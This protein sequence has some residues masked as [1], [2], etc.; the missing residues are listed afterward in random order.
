MVVG[1]LRV[2]QG[3][4]LLHALPIVSWVECCTRLLWQRSGP[5]LA[6][7]E[8]ALR[9]QGGRTDILW[10]VLLQHPEHDLLYL[11]D[12]FCSHHISHDTLHALIDVCLQDL[13]SGAPARPALFLPAP[14]CLPAPHMCEASLSWL[15]CHWAGSKHACLGSLSL[16]QPTGGRCSRFW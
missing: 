13:P 8:A 14:P 3:A 10:S 12:A 16:L 1:P 5:Q 11:E 9:C 4:V 15:A 2:S 7:E 6:Q